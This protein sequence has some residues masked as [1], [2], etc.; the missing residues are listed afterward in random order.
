MTQR[1]IALRRSSIRLDTG[2]CTTLVFWREILAARTPL[3]EQAQPT[4]GATGPGAG[5]TQSTGAK[6][7]SGVIADGMGTY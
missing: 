7:G 1:P 5:S 4:A 3:Y 2:W 6:I